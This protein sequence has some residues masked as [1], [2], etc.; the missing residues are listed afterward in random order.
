[1]PRRIRTV[2]SMLREDVQHYAASSER[3]AGHT[4]LLALNATIE[5]ARSGEAGRGFSIVAQEVKALAAQSRASAASFRADVL[6]RIGLAARFSDEM[7]AE[8]EGARLV[9]FART[10]MRQIT[11]ALA[12]RAVHLT[13]LATDPAILAALTQ[14]DEPARAA[15]AARLRILCRS[16]GQYVNAFVVDRPGRVAIASNPLASVRGHDFSQAEQ[17][18]RAMQSRGDDDWFTDAVWQNPFS[19]NRAVL[20]FVKAIRV[21]SG[22]PPLGVLYLEFDWQNLMDEVLIPAAENFAGQRD[23][24]IAIVDGEGR[25]IGSSWNAPFGSRITLPAGGREGIERRSDSVA[26]FASAEAYR[27]FSGLGL[28]CLIEQSMPSEEEI[29]ATIA[30]TGSIRRAA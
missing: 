8:V 23:T 25:L 1:M 7:L 15:G 12:A 26:A 28:R 13:L 22:E 20:V 16:S 10:V 29:R 21:R 19:G 6:D 5:A 4:N 17:F 2:L 18:G 3:I 14:D 24:R 30:E 9:E 27:S 11:R